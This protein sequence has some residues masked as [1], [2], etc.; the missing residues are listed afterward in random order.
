[1][2]SYS[3]AV[4]LSWLRI[5]CC[6]RRQDTRWRACCC[7]AVL[8]VVRIGLSVSAGNADRVAYRRLCSVVSMEG[9][10]CG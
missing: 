4:G 6:A 2:M 8:S 10:P 9:R 1:M 5:G 7:C 3:L